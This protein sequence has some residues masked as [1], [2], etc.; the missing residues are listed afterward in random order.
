MFLLAELEA[1]GYF[2]S[3][4]WGAIGG[5]GSWDQLFTKILISLIW[6]SYVLLF[7]RHIGKSSGYQEKAVVRD[8]EAFTLISEAFCCCPRATASTSLFS[9]EASIKYWW[10]VV[11]DGVRS[12]LSRG[13][14]FMPAKKEG[15]VIQ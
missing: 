7:S 9:S 6:V 14:T 5:E 1:I 4:I 3:A 2:L 13:K 15:D 11:R 12:R 10:K 8:V